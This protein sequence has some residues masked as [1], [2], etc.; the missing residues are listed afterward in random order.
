[1]SP[2]GR[3]IASV[4]EEDT[5]RIWDAGQFWPPAELKLATGPSQSDG[6]ANPP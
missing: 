3:R 6:E 1:M 5:A 2:D 4:S